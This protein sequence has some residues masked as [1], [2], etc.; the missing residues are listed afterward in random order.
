MPPRDQE[1]ELNSSLEDLRRKLYAAEAPQVASPVPVVTQAPP[2]PPQTVPAWAPPPAP[3]KK[4]VSW[5]LMF[6]IGA[7]ITFVIALSV[8]GY[9]L[10]FGT[11]AISSDRVDITVEPTPSLKSGEV[12]T[13]LIT[14]R[15]NNPTAI[16]HTNL[17]LTFPDSARDPDN[18]LNPYPRFDDTL[19][20]IPAG[21]TSTKSVRVALSGAEGQTYQIP[22]KLE[23]RTEGSNAVF[24][25]NV[26]HDVTISSSPLSVRVVL[27]PDTAL[28]QEL[29][30]QVT[31]HSD[32]PA[33]VDNVAILADSYPS[34]FIPAADSKSLIDIGTL[35]PGGDKTVTVSGTLV[36][37]DT[38]DR[39]FR[40]K[41]GTKGENG[42]LALVYASGQGQ[43]A[44]RKPFLDTRLTINNST[45]A[46]QVVPAGKQVSVGLSWANTLATALTD[47]QIE[48]QV[49]GGGVDTKSINAQSGY[50]RSADSTVIY[51]PDTTPGLSR[52]A[53]GDAGYGS[54]TFMTKSAS[55]LKNVRDASITITVKV[56]GRVN[57]GSNA[58][59]Q[60][61][62]TM[63]RTVQLATDLSLKAQAVRTTGGIKNTGPWPPVPD[64]E[65][66]Y[67]VLFT[68]TNSVNAV[69]GASVTAKLPS[70]VRYTGTTVPN[71]GSVTY[72]ATTRTVTWAAGDV[73]ANGATAKQ[74][75][76]QV[77]LLPSLSQ[78]GTSPVLVSQV[79]YAGT[80][81]VTK[82]A[83][84][85]TTYEVTTETV[86]D[87][88][89]QSSFGQ[90]VR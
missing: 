78:R 34:G 47:A 14:V 83:V 11:R 18:P 57:D 12:A 32:A 73:P 80:D 84:E 13:L 44:I 8:A 16:H 72:D 75:A 24:V 5:S 10:I 66:T 48:V 62:A 87:P 63:V 71:D 26:S 90:V 89:Y 56:T 41:A 3:P 79:S 31:V 60:V 39:V 54:F 51:A 74:M 88:Q 4:K 15:N 17:A 40:F 76:F 29:S 21:E 59:K 69:A 6:L 65:T 58:P 23:Y 43:I 45:D 1:E 86:A 52:V 67:T 49:T 25:K 42:T 46:T 81:R 70:Y 50:F 61:T 36:G 85:G 19:G 64:K 37:D 33:P 20:D 55:A 35:A 2:P 53:P 27:P 68:F 38:T 30:M 9:F 77:A 7:A 22:I 28:G 82:R